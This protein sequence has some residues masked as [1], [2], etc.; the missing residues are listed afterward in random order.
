MSK[1]IMLM[2]VNNKFNN[3]S[4][5]IIN[6][7]KK[8][9]IKFCF[10]KP[11]INFKKKNII[12]KK[13]NCFI[14]NNNKIYTKKIKNLTIL[15]KKNILIKELIS[16]Y[17]KNIKKYDIFIIEGFYLINNNYNYMFLNYEISKSLNFK[18][19]IPLFFNK[20]I[21]YKNI[22]K[23]IN[24]IYNNFKKYIN[25]K[26][27]KFIINQIYNNV[28]IKKF[29][30]NK[31][32]NYIPLNSNLF[33]IRIIDIGY[34]IKSNIINKGEI[35]TKRI[36][37]IIFCKNNIKNI[38]KYFCL[39]S[40]IIISLNKINEIF[41]ICLSVY[42]GI[43]LGAI[44]ITDYNVSNLLIKKFLNC[45]FLT[46]LTVFVIN[47]TSLKIFKIIKKIN[48]KIFNKDYI[49]IKKTQK[50]ISKYINLNLF[51]FKK[52]SKYKNFTPKE[53]IYKITEVSKNINKKIILPEGYEPRI[54]KAANI[55]YNKNI[56]E[57]ILLGNPDKIKKIAILNN[58]KFNKKIKIINPKNI[59]NNYINK[60]VQLRKHKGMNVEKAINELKNNTVLGIMMLENN[61]VDGLVSGSINTTANTIRPALQI[62]K[63]KPGI[64]L[65]SSI[66][67]MLLQNKVLI[68]GDCAI[69]INPTS[70]QLSEIAIESAKTAKLFNIKPKIAMIS[71]STGNSGIGKDVEKVKQAT[72][73]IK[74]KKPNLIID[75]PLQYDAAIIS[76]VAKKKAP[77][78]KVAGKANVIIFPDLNTG[79]TTY[80][81][82]QRSANIISIGPILQGIRKPVNDLSRGALIDD[83]VYTIAITAIQSKN[84]NF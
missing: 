47:K 13:K 67:F 80:K 51:K 57:C 34:Y 5:S 53:F 58:I 38:F 78:S 77:N 44:L 10:M 40:F 21:N 75:G 25:L 24:I 66:N 33:S 37:N 32:V 61:E 64:S 22:N 2:P 54:I 9:K 35:L 29:K 31:K 84:N 1:T 48:F 20:F 70:E 45:I 28:N 3:L 30:K 74:K 16:Y 27:N 18:N 19:I 82:V 60:L 73:L 68:Y 56:A 15:E 49:N 43:K 59:R 23:Y 11:I 6:I 52:Y 26:I 71:Y 72:I 62:I 7:L 41:K 42:N 46:N 8:K 39:N 14:L 69:N 76:N 83:I 81:A 55:C 12:K 36:K 79:N 65:V 63:T 17:Y 50:Y 4:L